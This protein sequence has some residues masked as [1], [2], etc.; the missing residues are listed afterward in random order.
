M[1]HIK[2]FEQYYAV[3][4]TPELASYLKNH[5]FSQMK[6]EDFASFGGTPENSYIRW[7][8]DEGINIAHIFSIVEDWNP[9]GEPEYIL[10][11]YI[12]IDDNGGHKD[13][14][15]SFKNDLAVDI[16]H[17]LSSIEKMVIEGLKKDISFQ[18]IIDT[19]KK[20]YTMGHDYDNMFGM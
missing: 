5:G 18:E 4:I 1:K 16:I 8:G 17:D 13:H 15:I 7:G 2:L 6:S 10:S 20:K 3:D 14:F 11:S 12:M 9:K 19:V